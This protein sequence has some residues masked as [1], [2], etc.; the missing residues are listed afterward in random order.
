MTITAKR[1]VPGSVLTASAAT[2]YTV[3]ASTRAVIKSASI[4]NTTAAAVPASVH[5]VPSG[6]AAAAA[7]TVINTR[8]V[9]PNETYACPELVNHVLG[10]G[11]FIQALGNG[12]TLMVSGVEIV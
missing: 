1:L 12:L 5:I 7:N 11:D 9:A 8:S 3:G 6:G 10:A 2:Y 4:A